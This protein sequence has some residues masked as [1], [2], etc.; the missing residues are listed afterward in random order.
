MSDNLI[1]ALRGELSFSCTCHA[2]ASIECQCEAVWPED[3][4]GKAADRIVKLEAI[5]DANDLV[6]VMTAQKDEAVKAEREAIL[7]IIHSHM[8][9]S[10]KTLKDIEHNDACLKLWQAI[11]KRGDV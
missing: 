4:A 10:S 7:S 6:L 1:K 8:R 5:V 3:V 2:Y 11:Q 9:D